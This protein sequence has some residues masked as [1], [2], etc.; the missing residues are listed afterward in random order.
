[1]PTI[2]LNSKSVYRFPEYV[3]GQYGELVVED[4]G[5]QTG[6]D[7][8]SLW[9]IWSLIDGNYHNVYIGMNSLVTDGRD[10]IAGRIEYVGI[11]RNIGPQND[12]DDY[13][14]TLLEITEL[15]INMADVFSSFD[16]IHDEIDYLALNDGVYGKAY[17]YE[18]SAGDDSV[19]ASPGDNILNGN[20]GNDEFDG[21][22]G[23]DTLDGG[24][25]NDTLN[26]GAG[27]DTLKGGSGNDTLEGGAGDDYLED[28][29]GSDKVYGGVGND[30]INNIG[31]SDL[32]DGGDGSDTLITDISSGFDERSFEIGFDTVAGTHGRLT[33]NL[34]QDMISGI[35]NFT[36]LGN[37]NAVVTGGYEDNIFMTDA[38]DDL[39]TGGA[40]NDTLDGG[41]GNDNIYAGAGNDTLTGGTGADTFHFY[42][43]DGNNTITDWNG[44][45]DKIKVYDTDGLEVDPLYEVTYNSLND[46][47]YT[48][49]DGTSLT[50]KNVKVPLANDGA[51]SVVNSGTST[52]PVLDF[53]LDSSKDPGD[54]GVTSID[55]VLKFDPTHASF[56]SFSFDSGLLGAANEA[57]AADGTITFGAIA[58]TPVST[59]KPL[60]TMTMADLDSANDFSVTVSDLNVD[61][62][63]LEGSVLLVGSP[64]SHA[65]TA[66]VV[67]RDGSTI[68][69]VDVVMSD[70]TNSSSY[71]SAADGSVSGSL[72]SG[73]ES[74]VTGSL[75]Y[76]NSTKAVSSQDALDA[77]KLS[78][79]MT[80]AAGTKNAF[81]FISADF[82]QDGKVSSQD[83]LAIL[84]YSVGLPTTE[85][86]KWVF[87]DTSGDYT[88]VSKSNTSYTEGVSIAELSADTTVSLTGILIGD[89]NDSYSGLIA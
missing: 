9:G 60:F 74:T 12:D 80:T 50:L 58:L 36:L 1:M 19:S 30:T 37:F 71:K 20:A 85:Q 56:T 88:G 70:G 35:E 32:F 40:G 83:A 48:L 65:V 87:V 72:T 10:I 4:Y 3:T 24:A 59:D 17:T 61:G 76:S 62:S 86:A 79:G 22:A 57:S 78:V 54:A 18:G 49:A 67:T 63:A 14:E 29:M 33:S 41:A 5:V 2:K 52:A 31:G 23:N 8:E 38:G 51:L 68:S 43:G 34:G 27:N 39:L 26:G 42:Y 15:D 46:V 6:S 82:N 25:G 45:E 81:D 84:K 7:T 47:V 53:Y 77:L 28:G 16:L 89:V 75:A 64:S 44:D 11:T 66:S 73:S 55:V 13:E 69:D 21:N